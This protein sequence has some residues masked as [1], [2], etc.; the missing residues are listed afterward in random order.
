MSRIYSAAQPTG[1][2]H[3]GNYFGAIKNWVDLQKQHEGI[4]SIV[5]LHALTVNPASA[6]LKEN[7]RNLAKIFLACGLDPRKNIIYRQS[8]VPE[9]SELAWILNCLTPISELERMTQFKDKAKQHKKNINAGLLT[10][11]CLMAADIL[12]YDTDMVPV[13]E[14]QLQHVELTKIIAKKFNRQYGDI[15]KIPQAEI[16]KNSARLK[17]LDNPEKKMSKSAASEYNYIALTDSPEQIKKKIMKAS[18]DSEA[19]VKYD[20]KRPGISNLISIYHLVSDQTIKQIEK[21]Y[22]GKGYGDFKKDL[23]EKVVDYLTPIREKYLATQDNELDKILQNG[24]I[25][26]GKIAK[27]KME[28]IKKQIGL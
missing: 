22:D 2:I 24:K 15:L 6:E 20:E 8:D 27:L 26:A 7:I 3:L 12:L 17:G 18:T 25:K 28:K 23:V 10:Y 4:F 9:H 19:S 13:G 21:K 1:I 11:P 14:D 5:D 16:N